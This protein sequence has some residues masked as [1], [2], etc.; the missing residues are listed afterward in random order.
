MV[1]N[2]PANAGDIR[3]LGSV[4][5]SARSSAEGKGNPLQFSCLKNPMDRGAWQYITSGVTKSQTRLK[6]LTCMHPY[7]VYPIKTGRIFHIWQPKK[8]IYAPF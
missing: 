8:I 4:P 5:G 1:K 3:D 7:P 2:W 6:Q